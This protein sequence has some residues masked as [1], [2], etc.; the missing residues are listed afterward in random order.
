[1]FSTLAGQPQT[2]NDI[3]A[4]P[5][6]ESHP[7][8]IALT[9]SDLRR[10][11]VV[12]T[13]GSGKS[14]FANK[15]AGH[16]NSPYLELDLLYWEPN[17]K[18][19]S[20][21]IFFK[22]IENALSNRL[23]WVLDGNYNRA[24]PVKWRQVTTVIWLDYSFPRVL[25]R[26]VKRALIRGIKR[27]ELWA[28]TGNRESL[29]KTFF[30]RKSIILWTVQTYDRMKDRYEKVEKDSNRSFNFVRLRS[31]R[32]ANEFLKTIKRHRRSVRAIEDYG[33]CYPNP[34]ILKVGDRIQLFK[35]GSPEKWK[36]WHWCKD[37]SG[38]EG[39]ISETYFKRSGKSDGT[40][41]IDYFAKEVAVQAGDAVDLIFTDC[42][43]C[44]K[45][46][47]DEGWLPTEILI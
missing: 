21:E 2:L 8:V 30:T 43:W 28:G 36:A 32:E 24:Q 17:W 23:N 26:A 39:W 15:L 40:I 13:S 18:E 10:V 47:G 46:D 1:M 45:T 6:A 12:G 41:I 4:P 27:E 11:N 20:D 33:I 19:P 5:D 3:P 38:N 35:K 42:G 34:L 9:H 29:F 25:Y 16:L 37:S 22:R 44:R 7:A 31:P 14:T